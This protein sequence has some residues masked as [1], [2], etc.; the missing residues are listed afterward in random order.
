MNQLHKNRRT[1]QFKYARYRDACVAA[2][3]QCL[4]DPVSFCVPLQQFESPQFSLVFLAGMPRIG[5]VA[6]TRYTDL[7]TLYNF[8]VDFY[9]RA[10]K[11]L[12]SINRR[13]T[14]F[15]AHLCLFVRGN[16]HDCGLT[17]RDGRVLLDGHRTKPVRLV[18]YVQMDEQLYLRWLPSIYHDIWLN[19]FKTF[20]HLVL[21]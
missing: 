11:R 21:T 2:A 9:R 16:K 13:Y 12:S 15:G 19:E 7:K 14:N 1:S 8:M 18:G 5:I 20:P 6:K 3:H 17:Q 10:M 4:Y